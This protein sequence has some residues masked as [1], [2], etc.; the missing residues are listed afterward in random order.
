MKVGDLEKCVGCG[1]SG[2]VVSTGVDGLDYDKV[3]AKST[4]VPLENSVLLVGMACRA[5]E[6]KAFRQA[7]PERGIC[8]SCG[9]PNRKAIDGDLGATRAFCDD[10]CI[11]LH[12]NKEEGLV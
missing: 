9:K 1:I 4:K 2:V 12:I 11:S 7:L 8:P 6:L 5:C 3:L 10:D